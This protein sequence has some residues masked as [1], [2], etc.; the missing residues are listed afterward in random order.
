MLK[1]LHVA[2]KDD[3]ILDDGEI[4]ILFDGSWQLLSLKVLVFNGDYWPLDEGI[5]PFKVDV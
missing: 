4:A 3:D 2:I 5:H 1:H